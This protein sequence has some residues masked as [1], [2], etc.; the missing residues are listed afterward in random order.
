M[1][2][3]FDDEDKLE[4]QDKKRFDDDDDEIEISL[5]Q[6]RA[7]HDKI[8][9]ND[10]NTGN[11]DFEEY[12]NLPKVDSFYAEDNLRECY[13]SYEYTR[14][15]DLEVLVD[16]HFNDSEFGKILANKKKIPKQILPNLFIAI[17]S[18]FTNNDYTASE[19]FICIADYFTIS[20]DILYENISSIHRAE[21]VKELDK[22]YNI[23]DKR[24]IK[25]LF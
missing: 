14:K 25:K 16:K 12:T 11:L 17:K 18:G 4:N 24:G 20:Y 1:S 21:L 8:F 22:K 13:D 2:R 5:S 15:F 10:Y 3:L 23:L 19:I 6:P 7:F 9:D